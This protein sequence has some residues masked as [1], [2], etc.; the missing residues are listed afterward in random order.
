MHNECKSRNKGVKNIW[1]SPSNLHKNKRT[2]ARF[3][4][5]LQNKQTAKILRKE[6]DSNMKEK[7]QHMFIS[8]QGYKMLHDQ[9]SNFFAECLR[10]V[11]EQLNTVESV[12]ISLA[13]TL[14]TSVYSL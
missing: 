10:S 2:V 12:K 3:L 9:V 1:P 14:C 4:F 11:V 5:V 7:L 8:N 6:N 13:D